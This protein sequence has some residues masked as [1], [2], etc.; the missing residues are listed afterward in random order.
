MT[1]KG[2]SR[3]SYRFVWDADAD[4]YAYRPENQKE[5]HDIFSVQGKVYRNLRFTVLLDPEPV[6]EA[7][8]VKKK[9]G[10][11]KKEPVTA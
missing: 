9:R 8:P 1:V 10:R 7:V 6:Q 3:K 4:Y 11:P 5:I 2:L